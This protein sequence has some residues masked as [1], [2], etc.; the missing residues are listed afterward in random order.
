[1]PGTEKARLAP[2]QFPPGLTYKIEAWVGDYA[3][4]IQTQMF[5]RGTIWVKN[6]EAVIK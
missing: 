5:G 3:V 1:V 4:V 6:T 2:Y